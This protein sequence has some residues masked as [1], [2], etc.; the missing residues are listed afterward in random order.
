MKKNQLSG[1][2]LIVSVICISIYYISSGD[3]SQKQS[4]GKTEPEKYQTTA[5]KQRETDDRALKRRL[6]ANM[7]RTAL[8]PRETQSTDEQLEWEELEKIQAP[9]WEQ[10]VA[11]AK[12]RIRDQELAEKG[13]VDQ[14]PVF[15]EQQLM[16]QKEDSQWT[17]DIETELKN[18]FEDE[19]EGRA[20]LD[21]VSCR[22]TTCKIVSTFDSQEET[23]IFFREVKREE[24]TFLNGLG[25]RFDK[26]MEDGKIRSV[27]YMSKEDK[28]LEFT[29]NVNNR[30]FETMT[31]MRFDDIKPSNE[32]I[33][34]WPY[35]K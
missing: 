18:R 12:R 23:T 34:A 22:E 33:V 6:L 3:A 1:L 25:N 24:K 15:M 13:Y 2:L 10:L 21:D 16:E 31:G 32:Q 4:T 35:A 8:T 29:E 30:M 14:L 5:V 7:R 9:T 20:S 17:Q 11:R 27:Y 19:L 28:S 26:R